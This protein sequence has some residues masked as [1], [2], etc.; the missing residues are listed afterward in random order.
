MA[1]LCRCHRS[2]G[3]CSLLSITLL[4]AELHM[5]VTGV[6]AA[7]GKSRVLGA[8]Y[9]LPA[10]ANQQASTDQNILLLRENLL[11]PYQRIT[12]E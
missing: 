2:P 11:Q 9:L 6:P 1:I 12:S 5:D 7:L 8:G 4:H 3:P 10:L